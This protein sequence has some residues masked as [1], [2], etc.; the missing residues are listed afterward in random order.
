MSLTLIRKFHQREF[1]PTMPNK[2]CSAMSLVSPLFQ[3]M[4][5]YLIQL[6]YWFKISS[7][8]TRSKCLLSDLRVIGSRLRQDMNCQHYLIVKVCLVRAFCLSESST[9]RKSFQQCQ[10]PC[11]SCQLYFNLCCDTPFTHSIFL[12]HFSKSN[13][14]L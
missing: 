9:K 1:M 8:D 2:C 6:I 11:L 4:L 12:S 13:Q 7:L 5:Q 10:S 14:P 3:L